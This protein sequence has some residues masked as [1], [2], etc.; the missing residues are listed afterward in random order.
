MENN[1]IYRV[2]IMYYEEFCGANGEH[3]EVEYHFFSYDDA[4]AKIEE[5]KAKLVEMKNKF[6]TKPDDWDENKYGIWET[7]DWDIGE[8]EE[9]MKL[10]AGNPYQDEEYYYLNL[11][12]TEI[13][14]L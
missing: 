3:V 13:T 4:K 9:V 10:V 11:E 5:L 6:N 2:A 8:G 1:K 14:V 7:G 12:P